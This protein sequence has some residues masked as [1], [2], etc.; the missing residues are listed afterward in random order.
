MSR[1][2][3]AQKICIMYNLCYTKDTKRA[4]LQ[5]DSSVDRSKDGGLLND[6]NNTT[7][8]VKVLSGVIFL[9]LFL[10]FWQSMITMPIVPWQRYLSMSTLHSL[11]NRNLLPSRF[12]S[13]LI[14]IT[15][16]IKRLPPLS[17]FLR[18][19]CTINV[20]KLE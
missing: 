6:L 4:E 5:L 7:Q 3:I 13:M 12:N 1:L 20:F 9:S 11:T 16:L 14:S 2:M 8:L 10:W 18:I 15:Y 19:Y 17:N